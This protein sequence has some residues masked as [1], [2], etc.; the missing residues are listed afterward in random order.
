VNAISYDA[1][2]PNIAE[3]RV[4]GASVQ[5]TWKCPETG[6]RVG[7]SSATM[8]SDASVGGRVKSSVKRSIV[9][10]ISSGAARFLGGLLG[11]AAGRVARDAAY[12]AASD[13]RSKADSALEY[14]EASR[15]AAIISTFSS[16]ESLFLW[17][18]RRQRF[19]AR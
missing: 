13:L 8:S 18:D 9:S 10:E 3:V 15:R 16:V 12:T 2:H 17:D 6:R 1:I 19:L 5:V 11:G 14:S 4:I 7:E